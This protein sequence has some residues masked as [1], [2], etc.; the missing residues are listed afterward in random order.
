MKEVGAAEDSHS[1]SHSNFRTSCAS[2]PI[3]AGSRRR[4]GP[5]AVGRLPA[6]AGER[7]AAGRRRSPMHPSAASRGRRTNV[8]VTVGEGAEFKTISDALKAVRYRYQ[9]GSSSTDQMVVKIAAGTYRREHFRRRDRRPRSPPRQRRTIRRT[10][11]RSEPDWPLGI[12]LQGRRRGFRRTVAEGN[13]HHRL[14][15]HFA[16]RRGG[17]SASKADAQPVAVEI[18]GDMSEA[19]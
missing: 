15:E 6:D 11:N 16:V 19:D 14:E 7:A 3:L 17:E 8:V 4:R 1:K 13:P 10:T 2:K 18:S 12:K 9:L 5:A